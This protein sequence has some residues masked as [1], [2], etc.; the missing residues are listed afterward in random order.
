MTTTTQG[1]SSTPEAQRIVV[2]VPSGSFTLAVDANANGRI[3]AAEVSA[4]ID[5]TAGVIGVQA[6]IDS[7]L[8]AGV[9]TVAS[10]SA[11]VYTVTWVANGNRPQL[12]AN[13]KVLSL[14]KGPYLRLAATGVDIT[15]GGVTLHA[16]VSFDR[17]GPPSSQVTR[18]AFANVTLSS[19]SSG[20]S[21]DN[22][23]LV[24]GQGALVF[25]TA[26]SHT[27]STTPATVTT[28]GGVA[29][30]LTGSA[31][32]G[33]GSFSLG[34]SVGVAFN[35]TGVVVNQTIPVGTT[36]IV[37]NLPA[38]PTV[39]FIIQNLNFDFG[40]VLWIKAG[41]FAIS[42]GQFSG[43]G[44]EIFVGRGPAT[45]PDGTDNPDA[46]G[47]SV[48]NATM[49]FKQGVSGGFA[50]HVTGTFALV[51]L[52]GL[53]VSGNVNFTANTSNGPI[54]LPDST[55]VDAGRYSFVATGVTISVA[56]VFT[57]QGTLALTREPN[58]DLNITLAPISVLVTVS[59]TNV[60]SIS[61]FATFTISS[62][63]GLQLQNFKVTDFAL[64]PTSSPTPPSSVTAP[65]LFPTATLAAPVKGAVV[66]S[67]PTTIDV[68]F[69]DVNGVGLNAP[70]ITDA[71]AEFDLLFNGASQSTVT[72]NGASTLVSGTT[73]RYS[74]SAP[75]AAGLWTVRF[76]QGA[77]SDNGGATNMSADQQFV[78]FTPTTNSPKPGP[79]ATLAN[80]A[81]GGT[82][83]AAQINAQGYID[84]TY[85]SL[86][87]TTG[88]TPD[89]I[90]KSS[91]E[92]SAVAPFTLTGSGVTGVTRDGGN[93]P[94]LLGAPLLISGRADTAT[95]V[96]Y[97]Y[98]LK[99]IDSTYATPL[100]SAGAVVVS[101]QA[102]RI[103]SGVAGG[104]LAAGTIQQ[105]LASTQSFTDRP[106]SPRR[107]DQRGSDR[108]R[109]AD[110][111][112]SERRAGRLRVLRRHGRPQHRPR[113]RPGVPGVRRAA[114]NNSTDAEH[115]ADQQRRQRQPARASWAPSTWRSTCSA[116]SAGTS[117]SSRPAS[118]ACGSRRS[119]AEVP[120][121]AKLTATG[122]VI[123]YDPAAPVGQELVRINTA[124]IE[125]PRF[126]IRGSLSP[127]NPAAH[128][129]IAAN[130]T[131]TLGTGVIPGLVIRDNGFSLG[132][133]ELD[134][135]VS[136]T[137]STNQLTPTASDGKISFGGIL[138]LN[139][140]RVGVS[141]LT[142][143][144]G[145]N[146]DFSGQIYI[147][148]GGAFL[149]PGQGV[150]GV[151]H[152]PRHG[153]RR[154]PRRDAEHR[155]LPDRA[156]VQ[157]RP[158]GRL[159]ADRRHP[160]DPARHLRDPVRARLQARHQRGR[161]DQCAGHV[162]LGRGEGH[163]RLAGDRRRGP[164][165]RL[166]R[167]RHLRDE[168]PASASSCRSGPR[169]ATPSSGRPSCP[170]ASTRSASSG[171]TSSTTRA[172]SS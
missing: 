144:F 119:T 172:T 137:P 106:V 48:R 93:V 128:S 164:Q 118:G 152:R 151:H 125:V 27:D 132:T 59:G 10:P 62:V 110:A 69:N 23:G 136:G 5:V 107:L 73:Y 123:S 80:P 113:R 171:T 147:A 84:V 109:P 29:G 60:A 111:P 14:P 158:R 105:N 42:A 97:R 135:G 46:I 52:D 20:V 149:F 162:R 37:V 57:I 65:T 101:F 155:G 103:Q 45:L 165:L 92:N 25:F 17:I 13:V 90:L 157:Q 117:G 36:S 70:T 127:Y 115:A 88:G 153:G 126:S 56:G 47:V 75:L 21:G 160:H 41:Q 35:T 53:T 3:D 31:Q 154:Q 95:T 63:S 44:L 91:I 28:T 51:G 12:V 66:S 163:H 166:P 72:V 89:P 76:V 134:Y 50:I 104:S 112:G 167:R 78:V 122:I 145:S 159:P 40:G 94:A 58:G 99:P 168:R 124:T 26:G 15:V 140:I 61:G 79:V 141:G 86:P 130:N 116:C 49:A 81:A 133:A 54:T 34:A 33:S 143:T 74:L 2:N 83:T 6:A 150:H 55:T 18:L 114:S 30:I 142:V 170:S 98:Y 148:T 85:T 71:S 7:L 161:D 38:T 24:S 102:N 8:G 108:P 64:F 169:P 131:D 1:T 129:N 9:A 120:N 77:F 87:G 82:I 68:T 156:D 4:P 67:G 121:V 22:P 100:F 146:V 16:D 43:T 96:T 32:V 139:D 138:V 19:G 11:A 39:S